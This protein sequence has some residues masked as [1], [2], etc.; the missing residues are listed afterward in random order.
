M[1]KK[2]LC[3]LLTGILA[4]TMAGC[5]TPATSGSSDSGSDS[6]ASDGEKVFRY[7]VTTEPSSLDPDLVNAVDEL[8]IQH[9][10]VEGLVRNT[11]G[12]ITPGIAETWDIS[13]DGLTYT[14]HLRDAQWSDGEAITADDFVYGWQRLMNPSTGSLY[15]Y[16]G[17]YVLN[18]KAVETGEMDP[19]EL[20]IKAIDEKTVEVQLENPTSYFLGVIGMHSIFAPVRQDIVEEYGTD[21]AATA[22]KNV[23]S[24]PFV[25][26]SAENKEYVL[27]KNDKYWDADSINLD[28]VVVSVVETTD[29][30]LAL[31]EDGELDYVQVPAAYVSQYQDQLAGSY[32]DGNSY[33]YFINTDNEFLS[34]QNFRLALNYAMNRNDYNALACDNVQTPNGSIVLPT[35]AGVDGTY[36]EEYTVDSYPL[37]GDE[38]KAKEYLAAAMEELNISDASEISFAITTS[39]DE[40]SKKMAEVVQEMWQNVLGIKVTIDQKTYNEIWGN[41]LPEFDYDICYGGWNA[42]YDDP[43]SFLELFKSDTAYKYTPYANDE[44]DELLNASLTETDAKTRMDELNQAEQILID[45]GAVIPLHMKTNNYMMN[46]KITGVEFCSVSI[47]LD[48]TYADVTE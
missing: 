18:G 6:S 37:D 48:W 47:A 14:F 19:S 17:E 29:T 5:S 33:W 43:Y 45:D 25:L 26:T 28:K 35:L 16:L 11:N 46:E 34:N 41:V 40:G 27:E 21:F 7:A 3:F 44:V 12:T 4:L 2:W 15:A 22:D 23:Y 20:G 39:D 31:Y 42:D 1:K 13:D 9:G 24:G 32:L 36:G 38:T 10:L 30:Q 8:G